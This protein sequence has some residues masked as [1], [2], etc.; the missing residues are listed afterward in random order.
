VANVPKE[1]PNAANREF[2]IF[3]D[4]SKIK[5]VLDMNFRTVN[6]S[7]KEIAVDFLKRDRDG[8]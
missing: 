6:D 1:L 7:A 2:S 3:L 5:R 8:W 4:N